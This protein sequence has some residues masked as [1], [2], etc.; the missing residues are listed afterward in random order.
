MSRETESLL[1]LL[2]D[3]DP[4]TQEKVRARLEELGWNAVYYG[5]QN[6]ERVIPLP[7]RRQVRRRLHDMSSV[8][9]VNEVQT[10]LGEGDFFFVPEGLYSL[11]RVLLPEMSPAEFHDCYAA[12]AGDLVC[13]LRDTMTAVEKVEMLNYIVFDRYGFKLSDDGW[14]GYETDVLIPEIMAGRRAGVVGITSV[15]FLLAS[16]AG[17]PVYP[18]FPKEPGYYVAWFEGGRTLF[19]MDMGN[20]GRIAEPIPRRSWLDTDF[21]G[22]DRT[23]L[24]LYATALRRF[25]RKPLTQFQASLLDRAV[26][27]LRL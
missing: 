24:Y 26:D 16:Y 25:G 15:Y 3:S 21:M 7:A 12:P 9:A 10:L 2:Q 6:L 4:V 13:E 23:I 20:K 17:L 1:E 27:S 22:T 5:L 18:V 14:D 19:S 11:T 8:C